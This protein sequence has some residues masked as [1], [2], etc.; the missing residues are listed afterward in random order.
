VSG[1]DAST[2][3]G[4][5]VVTGNFC[6]AN[7][8]AAA[9]YNRFLVGTVWNDDNDNSFFDPGEGI[10][11]VMVMPDVG[12]YYAVTSASGGYA[13]PLTETGSYEVTFSGTDPD[14]E[15]VKTIT[16]GNESVLLDLDD[17]SLTSNSGASSPQP[18]ASS[19]GGGSGGCF[20]VSGASAIRVSYLTPGW[21]SVPSF[22]GVFLV[23][24]SAVGK[25]KKKRRE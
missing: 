25:K 2:D 22:F 4:P 20:I 8:A 19:G 6:K 3:V 21:W 17:A 9:H 7:T 18:A 10:G 14:G 1:A 12:T 23:G 13:L 5:L 11:G 16:V 24:L 15:I